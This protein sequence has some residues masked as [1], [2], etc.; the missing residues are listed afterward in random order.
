MKIPSLTRDEKAFL[1]AIKDAQESTLDQEVKRFLQGSPL[2]RWFVRVQVK[3][4]RTKGGMATNTMKG[5]PDF[6]GVTTSGRFFV[7]EDKAEKGS[8]SKE[9][10]TWRERIKACSKSI[11]VEARS[12]EDVRMALDYGNERESV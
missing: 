8:L 5:F 11:Y 10:V 3:G 12:V 2:V 9:Q 7:V 1:K 4:F 6:M